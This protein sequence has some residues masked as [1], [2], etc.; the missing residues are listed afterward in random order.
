M[1]I[2]PNSVRCADLHNAY[3]EHAHAHGDRHP[4]TAQQLA[5]RLRKL[6]P[7][8]NL[9]VVRPRTQDGTELRPRHFALDT[10]EN[11]RAAFLEAM[12]IKHHEWPDPE[13]GS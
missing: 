3:T 2:G 7:G 1:T 11:C 13:A 12:G 6:C 5:V 8:G 4:L 9:K 10:A